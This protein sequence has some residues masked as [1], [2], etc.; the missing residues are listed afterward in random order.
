MA[1]NG[2]KKK[3][4]IYIYIYIYIDIDKSKETKIL[5]CIK[6]LLKVYR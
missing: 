5:K 1:Q 6:T 3:K 2:G 4:K